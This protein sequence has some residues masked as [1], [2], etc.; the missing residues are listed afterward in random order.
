MWVS[1]G[2]GGKK[3]LGNEKENPGSLAF[4]KVF[5]FYPEDERFERCTAMFTRFICSL[6]FT[7]FTCTSQKLIFIQG[8]RFVKFWLD[9]STMGFHMTCRVYH[10]DLT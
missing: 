7:R 4:L 8:R 9:I 3:K 1:G 10:F 5:Q 6:P 2:G